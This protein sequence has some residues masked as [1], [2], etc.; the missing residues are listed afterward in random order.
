MSSAETNHPLTAD[1]VIARTDKTITYGPMVPAAARCLLDGIAG[2]MNYTS[3]PGGTQLRIG[4]HG[5]ECTHDQWDPAVYSSIL[6]IAPLAAAEPG[7]GQDF[8]DMY[9]MLVAIH[10][11]DKAHT[12]WRDVCRYWNDARSWNDANAEAAAEQQSGTEGDAAPDAAEV[13]GELVSMISDIEHTLGHAGDHADVLRR[14]LPT[15]TRMY[16]EFAFIQADDIRL[17]LDDA[18]RHARNA[19][20]AAGMLEV[21]VKQADD[22]QQNPD[23]G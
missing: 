15:V 3:H 14:L 7:A 12:I 6:A 5:P 16:E 20:R 13:A 1:V 21:A 9:T 17:E 2:Q 10:G 4:V 22:E 19:L 11:L 23:A 8:P 18:A